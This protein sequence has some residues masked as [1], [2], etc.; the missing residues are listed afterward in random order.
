MND[1]NVNGNVF[2]VQRIWITRTR[3]RHL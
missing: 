1:F 2:I 3:Y